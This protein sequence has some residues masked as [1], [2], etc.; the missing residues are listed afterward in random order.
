MA[1][2]IKTPTPIP[3]LKIPS[4]TEQLESENNSAKTNSNLNGFFFMILIS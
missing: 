1:I 4:T 2:T 3:A